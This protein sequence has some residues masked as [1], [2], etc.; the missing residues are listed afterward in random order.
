MVSGNTPEFIYAQA[1]PALVFAGVQGD[2]V[3]GGSGGLTFVNSDGV[4]TLTGGTGSAL[5]Y[6]QPGGTVEFSGGS[7][8]NEFVAG[9][10]AETIYAAYATGSNLF[11]AGAGNVTLVAGSGADTMVAGSGSATMYGG[12]GGNSFEFVAGT[13]SGTSAGAVTIADFGSSAS[14]QIA[15]VGYGPN[16]VQ[17]A[18]ATATVSGGST[19]ITLPDNTSIAL[20]GVN[21]VNKFDFS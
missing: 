10:G 15:L 5:V 14:N 20:L 8:F 1:G 7:S 2:A 12:G 3:T 21:G 18:L 17:A 19:Y 9:A 6:D 4:S 13:S 16:A 11:F